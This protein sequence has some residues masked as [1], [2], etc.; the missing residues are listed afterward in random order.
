M[1][2]APQQNWQAFHSIVE[3]KQIE[4]DRLLSASQK[5]Q[6]YA[7]IFDLVWSLKTRPRDRARIDPFIDEK[8]QTRI[9]LLPAFQ[10]V[11]EP[12]CD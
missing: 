10:N 8:M 3:P 4:K 2:F 5:V 7:E 11:P 12:N 1:S 6:K 9:R